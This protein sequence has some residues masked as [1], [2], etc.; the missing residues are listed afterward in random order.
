MRL[1]ILL[2][3]TKKDFQIPINYN[4]ALSSALYKIFYESSP[5]FASWLHDQGFVARDGK[6]LKLFTFS[7]LFVHDFKQEREIIKG[8]RNCWFLFSSPFKTEIVENLIIGIF[9]RSRII[10]ANRSVSS[11]FR[12]QNIEHIEDPKFVREMDYIM[13]SPTVTST[14]KEL[15]GKV[16]EHFYRVDEEGIEEALANNLLKKYEIVNKSTY[17]G[18]LRIELDREYI[19]SK[20]GAEGVSK[21]VT[22]AEGSERETRVKGFMCPIKITADVEMQKVAYECG[23]GKK[24]GLGFGMLEVVNRTLK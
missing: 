17:N 14:M 21:M 1:K 24:N 10:I 18:E 19:R 22:I 16:Y 9:K 13:L 8:T 6:R 7:R 11:E 4:Y 15:N 3:S 20:G 5:E 23:I 2:K 12:V